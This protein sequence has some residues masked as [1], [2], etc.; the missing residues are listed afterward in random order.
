MKRTPERVF[1]ILGGS[2]IAGIPVVG[3]LWGT[4][5]QVLSLEF[6][7]DRLLISLPLL[8]AL[9]GFLVYFSRVL[10]GLV[11]SEEDTERGAGEADH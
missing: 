5:N 10:P 11:S 7:P 1:V 6:Q 2:V 3:Y 8:A 4:L 9:L